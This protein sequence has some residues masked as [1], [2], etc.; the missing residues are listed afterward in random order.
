MGKDKTTVKTI[1]ITTMVAAW[2]C[3]IAR[4]G[5]VRFPTVGA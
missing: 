2:V 4:M 3:R 5:A 1:I